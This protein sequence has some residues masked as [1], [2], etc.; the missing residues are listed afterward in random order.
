LIRDAFAAAAERGIRAAIIYDGGFAERDG[1][2]VG[3]QDEIAAICRDA[4]IALCGPNCMGILSPWQQTTS[5]LQEIRDPAGLA[6]NIAIVS[7]SGGLCVSLLTDVS[8]FGFS[9][10]VSC[11]NEAALNAAE[12]LDYLVDDPHTHA[13]GGFIESVR[14]PEHFAAAL[15]RAAALDKP[16]ALIKAGKHSR[17]RT[18]VAT[19]TSAAAGDPARFS[20][21][22]RAH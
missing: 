22:L 17:S 16:V 3:L 10:I 15:D 18:A 4:G 8:R 9:H 2:A 13:I 19:H 12:F 20:A 11:G 5:Y 21:M 1:E 6:G 7:H 14:D